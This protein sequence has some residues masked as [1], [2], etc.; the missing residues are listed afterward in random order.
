MASLTQTAI[1]S[2]KII[3]YAIY[4]LVAII[5]IRFAF[6]GL[7]SVYKI[8]FPPKPEPPDAKFGN[9]PALPFPEKYIDKNLTYVLETPNGQ[10]PQYGD[11]V[12]VY[13]MPQQYANLRSLE[14]ARKKANQLNFDPNGTPVVE[15]VQNVYLFRKTNAASTLTMNIITRVF[16]INYDINT[17]SKIFDNL[18]LA[19]DA[20]IAY[21]K[22]YLGSAGLMPA[23]LKDGP[24]TAQLLRV[25]GGN[26]VPAVSLSEANIT[27]VNFFRKNLGSD[28]EI[29]SVT[30]DIPEANVWFM[31]SGIGGRE[32]IA[33]EYQYYPLDENTTATYPLMTSG[34]A[35]DK[36]KKGQAYIANL[37]TNKGSEITIRKVYLAYYDAGQYVPF[38]QPVFVFVGDNG[39]YA[40]VPAVTDQYYSGSGSETE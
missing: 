1:L 10:L 23:D 13:S 21:V 8:L 25:E 14:D 3:R 11:Q 33:A 4:V 20:A 36:L 27:K 26:Y 40:Y 39:F 31:L 32:I 30:P 18:P 37:G 28:E 9:L 12:I 29:P 5:A 22:S 24:S 15:N 7:T 16:S 2:R 19:E 35:W 34:Q 38:Y 6:K 17:N